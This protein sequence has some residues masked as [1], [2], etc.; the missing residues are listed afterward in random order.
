VDRACKLTAAPQV[1]MPP[2]NIGHR[3]DDAGGRVAT[4]Q[5]DA[6]LPPF[7]LCFVFRFLTESLVGHCDDI[8]D[9]NTSRGG[10]PV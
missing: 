8:G 7:S 6:A 5:R 9:R 4:L 10:H 1:A 2:C 3:H